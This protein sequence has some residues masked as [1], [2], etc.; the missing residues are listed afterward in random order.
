MRKMVENCNDGTKKNIVC[1][2]T[3]CNAKDTNCTHFKQ[4]YKYPLMIYWFYFFLSIFGLDCIEQFLFVRF[5]QSLQH[6][7][8]IASIKPCVG[9]G[10]KKKYSKHT[11]IAIKL[12][13]FLGLC[14]FFFTQH[15][16]IS[17]WQL[18]V[19]LLTCKRYKCLQF[20]SFI[21]C[22][23]CCLSVSHFMFVF[24]RKLLNAT[25]GR[26]LILNVIWKKNKICPLC[27]AL[28]EFHQ[29]FIWLCFISFGKNSFL[30]DASS[31]DGISVDA[32]KW[33]NSN[34]N[35]IKNV[36]LRTSCLRL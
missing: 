3:D 23:S 31:L 1:D 18:V 29:Y 11:K 34:G 12:N 10:I 17:N 4:T 9:N 7:V 13:L 30:S 35:I 36:F 6:I 22:C 24:M 26:H 27:Y 25:L 5:W 32:L 2:S 20:D 19:R 8:F 33:T 16:L 28:H 15:R 21:F 14:T